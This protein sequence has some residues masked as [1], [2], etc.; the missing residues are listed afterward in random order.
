MPNEA[1]IQDLKIKKR[2]A[3]VDR[4]ILVMSGKGGVGKT[5]VT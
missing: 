1:E 5:T 3:L 2:M 4:K